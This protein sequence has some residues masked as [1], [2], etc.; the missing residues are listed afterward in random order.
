MLVNECA[1]QSNFPPKGYIIGAPK[2]G[3][4]ALAQYLSEH[5]QIAFSKP[6]EPHFYAD[7]L[8]GLRRTDDRDQYKSFFS[9]T[10]D[11][12]LLMEGSVWYLFS[13]TAIRAI[14]NERPDALFVIMLRNPAKM[15]PSLHRQLLNAFDEDERDF[16]T[17]WNLS[18]ARARGEQ[19]PKKCRATMTLDYKRT[20]AFGEMLERL[21][22]QVPREQ[23]LIL[24]QEEMQADT[25]GVY[26]RALDFLG[27]DDDGRRDFPR[28]NE[29]KRY[30]SR[31]LGYATNRMGAT[32]E[33]ISSPVKRVLGLRSLGITKRLKRANAASVGVSRLDPE[34]EDVIIQHYEED[35]RLLEGLI[36]GGLPEPFFRPRQSP[37]H[38]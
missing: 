37:Q 14:M 36:E 28:V 11:T 26:R 10:R 35:L 13:Q 33:V 4:T 22:S 16:K 12:R 20:A 27:L 1:F 38:L 30:R 8:P 3:T 21:W 17:A 24:F 32:R 25:G 5:P 18:D 29:A 34:M 31:L 7:D 2:C 6:K 9:P 19:I 15:L 23:T